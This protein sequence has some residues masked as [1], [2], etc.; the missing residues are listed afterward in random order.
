MESSVAE[1]WLPASFGFVVGLLTVTLA[2][3]WLRF[4]VALRREPTADLS[5][6]SKPQL[7]I[8]NIPLLAFAHPMPW[9]W[10]VALPGAGYYFVWVQ[11]STKA[12]WFF[13]VIGAMV[14]LWLV[15]SIV[16]WRVYSRRHNRRAT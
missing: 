13:G 2:G 3:S 16:L 10:L 5:G 8:I 15:A 6:S 9:L 12:A 7:R 4:A 11:S 14:S 1:I